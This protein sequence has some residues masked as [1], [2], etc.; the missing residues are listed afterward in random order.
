M[1][2]SEFNRIDADD[3]QWHKGTSLL[4]VR[5]ETRAICLKNQ[6]TVHHIQT[7]KCTVLNCLA[8]RSSIV[9]QGLLCM[10][11]LC[12]HTDFSLKKKKKKMTKSTNKSTIKIPDR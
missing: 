5:A 1:F 8:C 12:M 7:D 10:L 3:A 9:A 11:R 2:K 4:H 6:A